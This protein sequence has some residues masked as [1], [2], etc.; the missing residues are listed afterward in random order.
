MSD[1][2]GSKNENPEKHSSEGK[3][4]ML[5]KYLESD[6]TIT[7]ILAVKTSVNSVDASTAESVKQKTEYLKKWDAEW[8][9]ATK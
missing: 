8:K 3:L 6:A 4:V 7:E 9:A 1:K 5:K 2:P